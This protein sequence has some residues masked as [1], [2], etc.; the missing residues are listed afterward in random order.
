MNADCI[1]NIIGFLKP[2]E[3]MKISVDSV[4][5]YFPK[6]VSLKSYNEV[7]QFEQWCLSFD[8]SNLEEVDCIIDHVCWDFPADMKIGWVPPSVKKL[9]LSIFNPCELHIPDTV[10]ELYLNGCESIYGITLPLSLKKLILG[11]RFEGHNL[12]IP[13]AGLEEL[14]IIGWTDQEVESPIIL[15]NLPDSIHTIFL[16]WGIAAQIDRW[17]SGLKNLTIES[18]EDDMYG[19]WLAVEHAP[20]PEGVNFHHIVIPSLFDNHYDEW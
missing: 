12:V 16:S 5:R 20:V 18:Y 7:I 3:A 10:E 14:I 11:D 6:K 8:T 17:P 19:N 2:V 4:A 1:S 13:A 15:D 9:K